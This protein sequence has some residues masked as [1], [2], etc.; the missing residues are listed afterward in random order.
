MR[1]KKLKDSYYEVIK[2]VDYEVL[3]NDNGKGPYIIL[4]DLM[5]KGK[6]QTFA[7]LCR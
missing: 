1:F 2:L 5:Y 4:V 6:I 7:L 3:H